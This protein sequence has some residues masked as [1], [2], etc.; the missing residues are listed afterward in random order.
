MWVTGQSFMAV[1]GEALGFHAHTLSGAHWCYWQ[2]SHHQCSKCLESPSSLKFEGSRWMT[3]NL[4]L[5]FTVKIYT[6]KI[7][8]SSTF[9]GNAAVPDWIIAPGLPTETWQFDSQNSEQTDE[10][11]QVYPK[12]RERE[13][14][15]QGCLHKICFKPMAKK[16]FMTLWRFIHYQLS[17]FKIF[18]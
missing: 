16:A 10:P 2:C 11:H 4:H 13:R 3:L 8:L 18:L 12:M 5:E 1:R 17:Y 9:I 6:W 14:D 15:S 7:Q